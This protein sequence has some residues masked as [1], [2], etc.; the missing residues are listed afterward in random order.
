MRR[1]VYHDLG[2]NISPVRNISDLIVGSKGEGISK[3]FESD[4]DVLAIF[5]NTMCYDDVVRAT[6]KSEETVF[7]MTYTHPGYCILELVRQG[8][9]IDALITNSLIQFQ[10][11]YVLSAEK[12]QTQI[13]SV[14]F[15]FWT[16]SK[17]E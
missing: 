14:P 11:R 8:S 2:K 6:F 10:G 7:H 5:N 1:S 4:I 16:C 17:H 9:C 15:T 12:L 13:K 3:V